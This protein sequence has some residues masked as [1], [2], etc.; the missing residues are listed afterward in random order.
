MTA[1]F[2]D[3]AI[4]GAGP[5]GLFAV[6]Q[7]GMLRMR[8]H[9]IDA[10]D[11]VGGQCTAL[12]PEKPIY[13]IPGFAAIDAAQLI[14]RLMEQAAPFEPVYHLG[15]PVIDLAC[16]DDGAIWR[17]E[18]SAGTVIR[19]KAVMIAGGVGAFGPNR[20]PLKGLAD[21]EGRSVFYAVQRKAEL[22]GKRVV[23]AGG[24]DSAVDWAVALADIARHVYLVHRR[25]KFRAAPES[26]ARAEALAA[27]GRIEMV[28]PY[29]L[30]GLDGADG[31]LAGV[32]VAT[33]DGETRRLDADV[34]LAFFG[35][36][37]DLGPI[38]DWGIDLEK[39][40]IRIAPATCQTNL[41]GV[42]AIGDIATYPGKL[43]LILT[44][45]SE[46][47]MAAHAAFPRVYPDEILHF[48]HSTTTGIPAGA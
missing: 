2:T 16:E 46:A 26:V 35:L 13:D 38:H 6:F 1:Y 33:L 24:G 36:S 9:V 48:E 17:L 32:S 45:F 12:Y 41:R 14:D 40:H 20:P 10:L 18:T 29:Q 11:A 34:L 7:C 39:S 30:A 42:Y 37:M 27:E 22:A 28:I 44:G 25:P 19:A 8:C 47:A 23:I 31:R 15:Q 3:V 43:K 21:Y 5:V 4:I